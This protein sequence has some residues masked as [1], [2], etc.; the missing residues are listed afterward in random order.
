[1]SFDFLLAE[2]LGQWIHHVLYRVNSLYLDE[3]LF[4]VFT[5]DVKSLLYIL[6]LLVRPGL[7]SEGY[8]EEKENY[9]SSDDQ[10]CI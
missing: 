3:L 8:G 9:F 7:Y 2:R 6:G 5:Y 4:E 1:M 10:G